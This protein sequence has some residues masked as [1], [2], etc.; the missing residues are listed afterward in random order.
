MFRTEYKS[1]DEIKFSMRNYERIGILSCSVCAN[2]SDTG[3]K[4]GLELMKGLCEEWGK[5]VTGFLVF[6]ACVGSLMEYTM[7]KYIEPIRSRLDA[8]LVIS[9]AGGIKA[10]NLYSPGLPIVAAC[11][12]FGSMPL[13][14]R[15]GSH[16][17]LV[18]DALCPIC[19]DGH[20]VISYTAGICPVTECPLES[21]Y[22]FCENPPKAGSRKCTQDPGR[23]CVWVEIGEEAGKRG[24]D[25]KV[26]QELKLI[27]QDEVP[28]RMPSLVRQKAPLPLKKAAQF[29]TGELFNP[30]ADFIHWTR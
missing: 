9:C 22:G 27:H 20:C 23:N 11:D 17:S 15:G 26:L 2:L 12:S 5:D 30:Y 19:D 6:G 8:L 4:K 3:G 25:I 16:D 29:V 28:K 21:R 18:V 7:S 10:S 14:P 1:A 24:V 13:T